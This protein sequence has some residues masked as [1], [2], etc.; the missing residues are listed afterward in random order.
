[1][2]LPYCKLDTSWPT[3]DKVIISAFVPLIPTGYGNTTSTVSAGN[4]YH[5]LRSRSSTTA[6]VML[7]NY[8]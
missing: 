5:T 3:H 4:N 7:N 1:M 2:I 8:C 6:N